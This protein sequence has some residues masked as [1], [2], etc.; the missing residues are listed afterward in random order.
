[1]YLHNGQALKSSLLN[2]SLLILFVHLIILQPT[3]AHKPDIYLLF[4]RSYGE[5]LASP[6][7]LLTLKQDY[8]CSA[9]ASIKVI[10][11]SMFTV[12]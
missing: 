10:S 2:E 3:N 9:N 7:C 1:M 6:L 5:I 11:D 8:N 4:Q 12:F